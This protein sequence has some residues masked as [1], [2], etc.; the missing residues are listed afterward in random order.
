MFVSIVATFADK[1]DQMDEND[2]SIV[3]LQGQVEVHQ[4][5]KANAIDTLEFD[6]KD[7]Y[8]LADPLNCASEK[9]SEKAS[10][11]ESPASFV[12]P[13]VAAPQETEQAEADP[14][15]TDMV[16]IALQVMTLWLVFDG[17][18][19]WRLQK[20]EVEPKGDARKQARDQE[21]AAAKSAWVQMVKAARSG[22]EAGFK[23]AL[24]HHPVINEADAW[25]CTPLHF[26]A[27]GGSAAIASELLKLGAEVD[28]FDAVDETALHIAARTGGVSMCEV[29]FKGGSNID[30]VNKQGFTP[31]VVAAHANQEP[32]CRFLADSG[33]GVANLTDEEIPPLVVS[34]V[35]RKVLTGEASGETS[36]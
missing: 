16:R 3:L 11:V 5:T 21:E 17:F 36:E 9:A 20:Q 31:L 2:D 23:E 8:N 18:Q 10:H 27:A 26:A 4:R 7:E 19:K 22:D 28:A 25:G 12:E 15:G 24:L 13:A 14:P 1:A 32:A 35:V 6:D 34:Q 33:A 30:A 29:L